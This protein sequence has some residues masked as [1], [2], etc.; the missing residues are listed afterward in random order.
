MTHPDHPDIVDHFVLL[1][2]VLT[3]V[4]CVLSSR[5]CDD[6]VRINSLSDINTRIIFSVGPHLSSTYNTRRG[7]PASRS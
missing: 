7:G 1:V 6:L 3:T 2:R 5:T 4:E